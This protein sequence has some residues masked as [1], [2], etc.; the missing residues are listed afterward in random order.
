MSTYALLH[1]DVELAL[2]VN[3][4]E[5]LAAIGRER[6]VQ[7]KD[8]TVSKGCRGVVIAK[9][10]RRIPSDE[11]TPKSGDANFQHREARRGDKC[12]TRELD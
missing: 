7:L 3:L 5:L 11:S 1:E 4:D 2:I 8:K 9:D 10:G 12:W 6:N